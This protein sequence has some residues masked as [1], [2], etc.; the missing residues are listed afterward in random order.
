MPSLTPLDIVLAL[1]IMGFLALISYKKRIVSKSGLIAAFGVGIGVWLLASWTWFFLLLLFF[2]VT[3]LFTKVKYNR[4]RQIGA[5]QE[6]GGARAWKN[7][8]ANGILPFVFVLIAFILSFLGGGL[9]AQGRTDV[10]FGLWLLQSF[11]IMGIAFAA[12]LGALS[13]ATADTL[14]TEIGLLNPTPPRLITKPWKIVPPGTSG[15]ISLMGEIATIL[16]SLMIGGAAA[17]I[18]LPQWFT[19]LGTTLLP[20]VGTFAPVTMIIVAVVGGFIGCSVDSLFGASIQGMWLCRVCGKKTE[21]KSHCN[22]HAEY[23]R[24]NQFFDN[25]MVNLISGIIGALAAALLYVALL[26]IGFA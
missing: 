19:V 13:T 1:A 16:G 26:G 21:K 7:V 8:L 11:P 23:L 2:M 5:A 18:A 14:A 15:G 6:K 20:E 25:N 17:I 22:K 12:F 10:G 4:K 24:G 9:D 3:A